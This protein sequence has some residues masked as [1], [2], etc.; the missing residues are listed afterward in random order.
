VLYYTHFVSTLE[1]WTTL[2]LPEPQCSIRYL[3]ARTMPLMAPGTSGSVLNPN[4][5]DVSTRA[6]PPLGKSLL[7]VLRNKDILAFSNN[8]F[9]R[10]AISLQE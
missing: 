1:R 8:F 9:Q 3:D 2:D 7:H 10:Q 5:T 6:Q 4:S